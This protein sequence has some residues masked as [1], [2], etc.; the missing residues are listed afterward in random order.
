MLIRT[1]EITEYTIKSTK[2]GYS[3]A[4][5]G[6]PLLSLQNDCDE[7]P[8]L[9]VDWETHSRLDKKILGSKDHPAADTMHDYH[10][11]YYHTADN[12][13]NILRFA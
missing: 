3:R 11:V 6:V 8:S 12:K 2:I 7:T 1:K 4:A 10:A 5:M 13:R 9:S